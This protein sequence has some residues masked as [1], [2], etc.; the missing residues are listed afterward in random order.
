MN[1]ITEPQKKIVTAWNNTSRRGSSQWINDSLRFLTNLYSLTICG[2]LFPASFDWLYEKKFQDNRI[3]NFI[4][5][6]YVFSAIIQKVHI[7]GVK[8]RSE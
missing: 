6:G 5:Q 8:N 2:S 3:D 4:Y 1:K 7:I